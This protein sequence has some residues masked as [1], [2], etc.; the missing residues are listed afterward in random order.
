MLIFTRKF[1]SSDVNPLLQLA[2]PLIL[3]GLIESASPFFGTIFLAE[4]GQAEL[5]AGALVR[6]LF[7]TLMVIL[8]GTLTAISV[9]VAQKHGEKNEKAV[10]QILRDGS[11]LSFILTP[12]AILLLWFVAPIFLLFGQSA[13]VVELAQSYLRYLLGNFA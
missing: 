8:W 1:Y 13:A 10:S 2:I 12:P 11:I 7:F 6:G 9:L 3:T 4:L 5:A